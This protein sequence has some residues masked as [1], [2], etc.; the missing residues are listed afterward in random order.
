MTSITASPNT[1]E[2]SPFTPSL[3]AGREVQVSDSLRLAAVTES[4]RA[5][6]LN[7]KE[8]DTVTLS[9]ERSTVA[10]YGRDGRLSL[11]QSYA[12]D[13]QGRQMAAERLAAETREWFGFES[14]QAFTLT[15][16]GD[17]SREEI[18][19]IRKAL[20]RI[21]SLM[22]RSFGA[23]A[24]AGGQRYGL[25][26]LDT[27]AGVEVDIRQS[28]TILAAR[29]TGISALTYAADGQSQRAA[30]QASTVEGPDWPAAADEAAG[31][32]A[33][34]GIAP[35]RFADPLRNLFHHWAGEMRR[36]HRDFEP[37]VRMM[38]KA[39]FEQLQIRPQDIGQG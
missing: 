8:G 38:A 4:S 35:Q 33:E 3:V 30:D 1:L 18:R 9:L 11:N 24:A 13:T 34:T 12:E 32:V 28:M 31:I 10:V 20:H 15:V 26:G 6:T 14:Q 23:D 21:H 37:M 22:N 27:L 16:D 39:V 17:L 19:D 7:T 2:P 36:R 5:I 29:T 25:S